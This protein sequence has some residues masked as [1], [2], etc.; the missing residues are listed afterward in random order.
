[1]AVSTCAASSRVGSRINTRGLWLM[2]RSLRKD[3]QRKGG[4]FAGA[5]LR[6]ADDIAPVE[7]Q[8]YGAELDG[9][10]LDVAHGFHA[11]YHP[12]GQS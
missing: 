8:R 5:G 7:D 1:M 4:G 3:R 12:F 11:L 10:G 9:R 2:C 6:A